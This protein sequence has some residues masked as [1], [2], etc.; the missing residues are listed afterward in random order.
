MRKAFWVAVLLFSLV[1]GV[2]YAGK[3]QPVTIPTWDEGL[4]NKYVCT[5]RAWGHTEQ[6]FVAVFP[7]TGVAVAESSISGSKK[8]IIDVTSCLNT[9][10]EKLGYTIR[11]TSLHFSVPGYG[12]RYVKI[13]ATISPKK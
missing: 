2:A 11:S 6:V 7:H 4:Q 3:P 9:V 10:L 5:F 12:F 8:P 1:S 13:I